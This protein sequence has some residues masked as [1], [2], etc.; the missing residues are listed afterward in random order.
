MFFN[1]N[2][3]FRSNGWFAM[4]FTDPLDL[5]VIWLLWLITPDVLPWKHGR[6]C[7]NFEKELFSFENSLPGEPAHLIHYP[8]KKPIEGSFSQQ[9]TE[10][11]QHIPFL[12]FFPAPHLPLFML[13]LPAFVALC[14]HCLSTRSPLERLVWK[15]PWSVGAPAL[16]CAAVNWTWVIN[17]SN[18]LQS[19]T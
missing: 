12:Y 6:M 2:V 18:I 4:C 13:W 19:G 5:W 15:P 1:I 8:A 17:E 7:Q 11:L 10:H 16:M 14:A 3:C 9:Q